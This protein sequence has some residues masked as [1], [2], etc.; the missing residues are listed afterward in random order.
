[1]KAF[2]VLAMVGM[3]SCTKSGSDANERLAREDVNFLVH[4]SESDVAELERGLPEGAKR[5]GG[6]DLSKRTA[7]EIATVR[8]QVLD[9]NSAK[10]VVFGV[11]NLE[12]K[13][14]ATDAEKDPFAGNPVGQDM[15]RVFEGT[16]TMPLSGNVLPRERKGKQEGAYVATSA[17][18]DTKGNINGYFVT[19]ISLAEYAYRLHEALKSHWSERVRGAPKG[20]DIVPIFYVVLA[21]PNELF[22]APKVPAVNV[23]A[24]KAEGVFAKATA[25]LSSSNLTITGRKFAYAVAIMPRLGGDVA[26]AVLHSEP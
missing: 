3:T 6:D 21:T 13:W 12:G 19:T 1:M 9:L 22:P 10:T 4:T 24:L 26:V 7:T 16:K 15:Q 17:L 5:L 8:R 11:A 18:R 14:L 23:D 20:G 25:G 2:I